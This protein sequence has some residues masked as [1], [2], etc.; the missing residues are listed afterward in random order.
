MKSSEQPDKQLV[1]DIEIK[2]FSCYELVSEEDLFAEDSKI[3][4]VTESCWMR[5]SLMVEG[6]K[7]STKEFINIVFN[8]AQLASHTLAWTISVLYFLSPFP[9]TTALYRRGRLSTYLAISSYFMILVTSRC[10]TTAGEDEH[11]R[12]NGVYWEKLPSE[13]MV[14]QFSAKKRSKQSNLVKNELEVLF[15]EQT[16]NFIFNIRQFLVVRNIALRKAAK[17]DERIRPL[18]INVHID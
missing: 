13:I 4:N 2:V 1:I 8:R 18:R 7:G 17:G 11:P 5:L 10:Q 9:S 14:R 15:H 6:R 16:I 12:S 3:K